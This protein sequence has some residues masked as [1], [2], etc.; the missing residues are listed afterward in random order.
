MWYN[1]ILPDCK[2]IKDK[3]GMCRN[4]FED[5]LWSTVLW[6]SIDHRMMF[7]PYVLLVGSHGVAA[8]TDA[9]K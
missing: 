5:S 1:H 4:I 7:L 8:A 3:Y 9:D 2:Y 6:N